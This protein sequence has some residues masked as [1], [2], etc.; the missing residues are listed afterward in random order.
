[1]SEQS[2]EES[3]YFCRDVETNECLIRSLY[4]KHNDVPDKLVSVVDQIMSKEQSVNR[5]KYTRVYSDLINYNIIRIQ[6][7]G[8][9]S[10]IH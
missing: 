9:S 3:C 2:N 8:C 4:H 5:S 6:L 10:T 7:K 1:M